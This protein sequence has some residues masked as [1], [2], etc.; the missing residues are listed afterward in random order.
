MDAL[1]SHIVGVIT[2]WI[3]V[4]PNNFQPPAV[5][6]I[7][8]LDDKASH[9]PPV[10]CVWPMRRRA[11]CLSGVVYSRSYSRGSPSPTVIFFGCHDHSS[12]G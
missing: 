11:R 1:F 10:M 4:K 12:V 9:P 2:L 7:L 8:H 6:V 3:V 5:D